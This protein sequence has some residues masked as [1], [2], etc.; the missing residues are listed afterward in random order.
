MHIPYEEILG[1]PSDFRVSYRFYTKEE[2]GRQTIIPYQGYRSDFWYDHPTHKV[3]GIFMIWPEFEDEDGKII[4][5]DHKSV[6]P[7][8]TARMW[9]IVPERRP[10]HQN[11][12][13]V[14]LKGYFMEGSKRV[15]E[16]EVIEV[17]NLKTNP[18]STPL[19]R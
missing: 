6:L 4:L 7:N 12:I 5:E 10:Y 3:N 15:A 9:I 1:H 14:G 16:C 17:L 8:G 2:G 13:H 11:K 19:K 18:T